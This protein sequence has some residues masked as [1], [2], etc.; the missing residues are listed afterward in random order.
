VAHAFNPSRERQMD[1]CEFQANP[2]YR[3]SSRPARATER[4]P[5]S[6]N[7]N[8]KSKPKTTTKKQNKQTVNE[9]YSSG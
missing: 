3:L 4:N 7:K 1:L 6:E 2:V 5:V 8:Q 9:G